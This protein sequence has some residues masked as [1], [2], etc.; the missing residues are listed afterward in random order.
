MPANGWIKLHRKIKDNILWQDK[1]FSKGQAWV[2]ILLDVNHS[3]NKILLG[4]EAITVE[5]GEKITSIRKL[6]ERWGW[7]NTKV[8][9]FLEL[10]VDEE[11]IEYKS[12]TKKTRLKVLNYGDYQHSDKCKNDAKATQERRKDISKTTQEHTNKN[13]KN[14]KNDKE[15]EINKYADKISAVHNHWLELLDDV[16][17]ARLT[18]KQKKT[19]LTKIKKWSANK[20]KKAI[21]N[22]NEIYR[23]DYYYSHNFT[24]YKFI[25]QSNGAPRFLEGLNDKYDGDIWKDYIKNKNENNQDDPLAGFK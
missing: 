16:N 1:P 2:D 8:K 11:M 22:Y 17:E 23:S 24:M 12:D 5:V 6:C 14:V 21:G 7:S 4:N 20:L 18:K 13:V 3:E 10:L 9:N 15:K 19:I 25:K